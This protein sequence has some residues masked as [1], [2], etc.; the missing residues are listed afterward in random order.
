MVQRLRLTWPYTRD[1]DGM[2]VERIVERIVEAA[3]E[4]EIFLPR[5]GLPGRHYWLTKWAI[6][7][8]KYLSSGAHGDR[9]GSGATVPVRPIEVRGAFGISGVFPLPRPTTIF[10]NRKR[11]NCKFHNLTSVWV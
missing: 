5:A 10:L 1:Y 6:A 7:H 4:F 8:S 3:C 9:G 11:P 2:I